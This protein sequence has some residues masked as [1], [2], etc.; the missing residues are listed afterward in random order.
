M[1][2]TREYYSAFVEFEDGACMDL[3]FVT[4]GYNRRLAT[5]EQA[6][7]VI[8]ITKRGYSKKDMK[9]TYSDGTYEWLSYN[10]Q[11]NLKYIIEKHCDTYETLYEE[12]CPKTKKELKDGID[13]ISIAI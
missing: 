8:A 5:Y 1:K 13:E 11:H 12:E 3:G 10:D 6:L 4:K 9:R 2:K 7:E